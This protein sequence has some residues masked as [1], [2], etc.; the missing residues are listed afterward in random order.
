MK[1]IRNTKSRVLALLLCLCMMATLLPT[2]A[3][4][5][6]ADA[7]AYEISFT[8]K[9]ADART[10]TVTVTDTDALT[11]AGV[12]SIRFTA[13]MAYEG[14]V[15][16]EDVFTC[17]L[18]EASEEGTLEIE[19]PYFGKWSITTAFLKGDT[20]VQENEA[21]TVNVSASEYNIVCGTATT[22]VLIESLKW[23]NGDGGI[24]ADLPTIVTLNRY[25]QYDWENLPE[26]MYR[27]PLL[28]SAENGAP[29]DWD[30][31]MD[32]M[33][34][35]VKD[36]YEINE[37]AKFNFYITDYH[38]YAFAKICYAN[39][40][41]AENYSLTMVS[42]GSG[43]YTA[44]NEA[45]GSSDDAGT[46]HEKLVQE[47]TAFRNGVYAGSVT[48]LKNLSSGNI[49]MYAY[50]ILDVEK[51]AGADAKWWV[52]RKSTD[53]FGLEND[54][55]F[56]AKVIADDRITNNYIN[57]LLGS[58]S[59]AGK[60]E[61]FKALYKFDDEGFQKARDD[62]KKIMMFLGTTASIEK[63]IPVMDYINFVVKYYGDEYAYFY[64]GHPGN[65]L[66]DLDKYKQPYWNI[67]VDVLE[68]SIAAELFIY[69][70]PDIAIS[71]YE[72]SL[73]QNM[74][75]D[76]QDVALFRRT[77]EVAKADR[78]LGDYA[79]K[80]DV[81][82]SDMTQ[83]ND[84]FTFNGT[85]KQANVNGLSVDYTNQPENNAETYGG[86]N[87]V[88]TAV[89][90]L[91]PAEE[92]TDHN[93]LVQF[94]NRDEKRVSKYDY[95]IWNADKGVIH[96]VTGDLYGGLVLAKEFTITASASQGGSIT[97][98]GAVTVV[99]GESQT[100]TIKADDNY[101]IEDVKVDGVSVGAVS[102]YTFSNVTAD[103]EIKVSFKKTST[104]GGGSGSWTPS[105]STTVETGS[106]ANGSFTV[107]DKN[108]K[109]G[110][111]VKVTPKANE[112]YVV[113][114]VTVTDK[115]G[116]AIEV[117]ANADGTYS[118]VMPEKA[119]QPV[120]VKVTFR[121]NTVA[122][123]FTDVPVNAYYADAVAWAVEKGITNGT[124]ATTFSPEASCTRA[125]IVT[126]LWRAAGSP[127]PASSTNPFTDVDV[128]SYYGKAVLWAVEKGITN[129]TSAT[130]FSPDDTCTRA[131]AVTFLYRYEGTPAASGSSFGDVANNAYYAAAVAWAVR[132]EIT[133]GTGANTFSPDN[134]CTRSQ[135]VT[136]LYRD[137]AE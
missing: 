118:F 80:M 122:D 93:Y 43:S 98:S 22:D 56:Q 10:V 132:E 76:D 136:L 20:P 106:T 77:M 79:T 34:Q 88:R 31:R 4:A 78:T 91:I 66:M 37:D 61:E 68:A 32:H 81:F 15:T 102:E 113:D 92:E 123:V 65:Y 59:S 51:T 39:K 126:F 55:D 63:A 110:D 100:F 45:Y 26:N 116:H 50:A 87:Q 105:P 67:G 82:I 117:T 95:A 41:P 89:A 57:N 94:N 33:K 85:S 13:T 137:M 12:D 72:S 60:D 49:R 129:G 38:M 53:T 133:N 44:F 30:V 14:T 70:N 120:T 11:E 1:N 99:E 47:Y 124:S 40:I 75:N 127:E 130:T 9:M 3:F 58:M 16:E 109:V 97:P 54:S 8:Q 119:A 24:D 28:S 125:Q 71:G 2:M 112:G 29:Q 135:I 90:A 46:T 83:L 27:N 7:A 115:N 36:L 35:Y 107:S 128:N 134:T 48:D 23:F 86:A 131:Q 69:F 73:F 121:E 18:S 21:A 52:I 17:P 103:A 5:A 25:W 111:T 108:A 64:K 84:P 74:G 6:E 62:G 42:D 114:Q 19:L 104:G 96:Y 101:T